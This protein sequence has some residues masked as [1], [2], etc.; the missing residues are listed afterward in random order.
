MMHRAPIKCFHLREQLKSEVCY[1]QKTRT[2]DLSKDLHPSTA[3]LRFMIV[4]MDYL[5]LMNYAFV[6]FSAGNE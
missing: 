2:M 4:M 3:V 5:G 6:D 1:I